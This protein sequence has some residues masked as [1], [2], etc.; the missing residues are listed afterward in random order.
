MTRRGGAFKGGRPTGAPLY[1]R[2]SVALGIGRV[3]VRPDAALTGRGLFAR[4]CKS[5]LSRGR[6]VPRARDA[7]SNT[8]KQGLQIGR[9][10]QNSLEK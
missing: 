9:G 10:P 3:A 7:P 8:W 6:I 4:A 5:G 2:S 1:W